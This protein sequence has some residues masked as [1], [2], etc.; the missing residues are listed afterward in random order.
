MPKGCLAYALLASFT[1]GTPVVAYHLTYPSDELMCDTDRECELLTGYPYDTAVNPESP[2][3][4]RLVG[5]GC[6]GANG[7]IY[8]FEEDHFPT[9]EV[10]E[11][12]DWDW[13][14]RFR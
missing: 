12:M 11:R 6:K 9:C 5:Y 13:K 2:T 7:P 1:V 4:P 14:N 10:I 8:A 3:Y